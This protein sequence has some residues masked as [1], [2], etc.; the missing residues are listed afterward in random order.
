MSITHLLLGL[1]LGVTARRHR[2]RLTHLQQL[3]L[4][5]ITSDVIDVTVRATRRAFDFVSR[6]HFVDAALTQRVLAVED[7]WMFVGVV[8]VRTLEHLLQFHYSCHFKVVL[9][10]FGNANEQYKS[11]LYFV[12]QMSV[13][14]RISL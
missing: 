8:T 10:V 4:I 9:L 11:T 5:D 7:L 13:F 1:A 6:P 3:L 14:T 2:L 12:T